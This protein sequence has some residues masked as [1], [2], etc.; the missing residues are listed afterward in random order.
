VWTLWFLAQVLFAVDVVLVLA[1]GLAT[2]L[3][4]LRIVKPDLLPGVLPELAR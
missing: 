4:V 1:A 2:V 3:L